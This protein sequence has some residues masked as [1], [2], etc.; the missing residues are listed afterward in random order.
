MPVPEAGIQVFDSSDI[1][2]CAY[3][4]LRTDVRGWFEIDSI[5]P[6]TY[7]VGAAK[8]ERRGR[9][10]S[11]EVIAGKTAEVKVELP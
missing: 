5:A 6:G 7:T 10:K 11:V 2:R 4:E 3:Y 1:K 9:S 8:S